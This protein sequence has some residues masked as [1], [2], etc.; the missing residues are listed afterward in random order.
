MS[1]NDIIFNITKDEIKKGDEILKKKIPSN[2]N[3]IVLLCCRDAGYY[4]RYYSEG[5][6]DY[7]DYRNYD[8]NIFNETID[9][10]VNKKYIV[11][12]MGKH[13]DQK[14]NFINEYFIDYINC[15]WNSDFMDYYLAH[16][17]KFCIT[18]NTGMDC[19]A[20]LHRKP[21][22]SIFFP[23]EDIYYSQKNVYNLSGT[24]TDL[25]NGKSLNL[26]EIFRNKLHKFSVIH[27]FYN[28]RLNK[29]FK[30]K[31]NNSSEIRKF[32]EEVDRRIDSRYVISEN[33]DIN[34][35]KFWKI[36]FEMSD[37]F[38][39]PLFKER[40]IEKICNFSYSYLRDNKEFLN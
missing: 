27:N 20:R 31:Y 12:R 25:N 23:L 30:F 1:K 28:L 39:D 35:R 34:Q 5:S 26:K 22:A 8:I 38:D 17:S 36:F 10:L 6:W 3:G 32:I 16:K 33:D 37:N 14:I 11:L 21:I 29:K 7:L 13:S 2:N 19:F 9:Y 24:F 18:T 15:D 4:S 40:E